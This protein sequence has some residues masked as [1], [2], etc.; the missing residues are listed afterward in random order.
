VQHCSNLVS[1]ALESFINTFIGYREVGVEK[2][3]PKETT[4]P[5]SITMASST[6]SSKRPLTN[7][8]KDELY[9]SQS[10]EQSLTPPETPPAQEGQARL[11]HN[12]PEPDIA[13]EGAPAAKRR[14]IDNSRDVQIEVEEFD[15]KEQDVLLLHAPKQRYA[16]TKKHPIPRIEND[17]EMLVAV[18]VVGLNPIDWKAP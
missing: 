9:R 7:I 10:L 2:S 14:K 15:A 6:S 11:M 12:W 1:C 17:R 3:R 5:Y 18:D 13:I 8:S 16:Y 4:A